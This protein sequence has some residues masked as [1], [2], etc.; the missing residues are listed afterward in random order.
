MN[1]PILEAFAQSM[2]KYLFKIVI[3]IEFFLI[4]F[5]CGSYYTTPSLKYGSAVGGY[6]IPR[7]D[8]GEGKL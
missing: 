4:E 5:S 8:G 3:F 2:L 1:F 6:E 7:A